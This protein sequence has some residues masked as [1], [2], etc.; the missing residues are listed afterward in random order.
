MRTFAAPLFAAVVLLAVSAR[1]D[2]WNKTYQVSGTPELQITTSDAGVEV[3]SWDKNEVGI[4]VKTE[5]IKI[6]SGYNELRVTAHQQGN[7]VTLEVREPHSFGIHFGWTHIR[8]LVVVNVPR[9]AN[10]HVHT[11]DGH[12]RVEQV[13]GNLDLSSGDGSQEVRK[14]NG[15]LRAHAGDGHVH[16]AGRFDALDVK[17]GD[18]SIEAVALPGSK[19]GTGWTLHTGDGHL[20]LRLPEK[21]GAELDIHTGDGHIDLHL[22]VQVTGRMGSNAMHGILNGGG[23]LVTLR[24]GDGSIKV[25][26]STDMI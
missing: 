16:V 10:L 12:I 4:Q 20:D 8:E 1:A 9:A 6:G 7:N 14:A 3:Q 11:Q 2:E 26:S 5:N 25:E 23:G 18:G 17:T 13:S 24:S 22:P 15:T 21:I 19:I